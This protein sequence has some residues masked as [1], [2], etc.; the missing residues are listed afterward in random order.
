MRLKNIFSLYQPSHERIGSIE[1]KWAQKDWKRQERDPLLFPYYRESRK[2]EAQEGAPNIAHHDACGRFV[3]I[4]NPRAPPANATERF[5]IVDEP[6]KADMQNAREAISAPW[7][8]ASPSIP[9][10][11]L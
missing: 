8:P 3:K 6:E 9:S 4:K 5:E 2:K 7:L 1:Q 10:M 11:K